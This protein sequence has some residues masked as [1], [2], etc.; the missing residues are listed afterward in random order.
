MNLTTTVFITGSLVLASGCSSTSFEA[1]YDFDPGAN[2]AELQTYSWATGA[3]VGDVSG[4]LVELGALGVLGVR[5][6]RVD[7]TFH[8]KRGESLA[9]QGPNPVQQLF[10]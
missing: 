4:H 3:I 8:F 6:G 7:Q 9:V 5:G 1:T 2:F 10:V